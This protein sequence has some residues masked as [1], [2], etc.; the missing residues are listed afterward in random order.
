MKDYF[1]LHEAS[2]FKEDSGIKHLFALNQSFA[3]AIEQVETDF[4]RSKK[5]SK[6]ILVD[7][8]CNENSPVFVKFK[9]SQDAFEQTKM[10]I[11]D[12][13]DLE[14]TEGE[15]ALFKESKEIAFKVFYQTKPDAEF[16]FR[17]L[18]FVTTA[19][20][21]PKVYVALEHKLEKE[22]DKEIYNKY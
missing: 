8:W 4:E 5:N 9:T 14:L 21:K 22:Y 16:M 20:L 19:N 17:G 13:L 6:Q 12:E 10:F 15:H 18:I 2:L 11:M 3:V 1:I 7:T